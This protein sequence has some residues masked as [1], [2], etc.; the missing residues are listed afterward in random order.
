MPPLFISG[1]CSAGRR[2][3]AAG[4]TGSS[5]SSCSPSSPSAAFGNRSP[6]SSGRTPR[7]AGRTSPSRRSASRW[8]ISTTSTRSGSTFLLSCFVDLFE[9]SF[10]PLGNLSSTMSTSPP[11]LPSTRRSCQSTTREMTATSARPTS[12]A[13]T[14]S[15]RLPNSSATTRS[16]PPPHSNATRCSEIRSN[17]YLSPLLPNKRGQMLCELNRAHAT[18]N[19]DYLDSRVH[20]F[21]SFVAL[22]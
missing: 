8:C 18:F 10:Q 3:A 12:P 7:S 13:S 15:S 1:T 11:A 6:G 4:C 14:V 16:T 21:T 2:T 20:H 17:Y 5:C 9:V 22:K 19:H